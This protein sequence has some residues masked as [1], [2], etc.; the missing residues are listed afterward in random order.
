ME[1][2]SMRAYA[3]ARRRPRLRA[4]LE[5]DALANERIKSPI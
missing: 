2:S 4:R 1:E 3:P 5:A